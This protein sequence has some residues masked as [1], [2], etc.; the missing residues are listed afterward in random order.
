M[1]NGKD[2]KGQIAIHIGSEGGQISGAET[3]RH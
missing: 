3:G 1:K 2:E